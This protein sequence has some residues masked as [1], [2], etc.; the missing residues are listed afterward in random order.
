VGFVPTMGALHAG[1]LSLI[2]RALQ[3]DDRVVV[4]IFVNPMQFGPK[5]DYARYPR[6]LRKDA[7]LCR[8][9]GAHALYRPSAAAMYPAGFRTRVEVEGLGEVLCGRFRPGHFSGVA[10]VVL[11]L[12]NQI[13]PHRLYLGEK[14]YQQLAVL[15]RMA[16]D[17]DLPVRV[18]GCP[19]V[20][21][22][23]GLALSS[24]NVRL[25]RS[26]RLL[27]PG[28]HDALLAG[29]VRRRGATLAALRGRMRRAARLIP[30]ARLDYL[31][32]VDARTL[33]RPA[34][35]R[36]RLRLLGALRLGKTRLIDNI[37]LP[38][39]AS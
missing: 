32:V 25:S 33:E 18:V 16:A 22:P 38:M 5:E 9:A 4:S 7:A 39:E 20:R 8:A 13:R 36:G 17:L 10:T 24:R 35:I 19:T 37:P 3:D 6:P 30:R 23:D 12:L 2:A 27:A 21:E 1:H 26:E 15:R 28:L 31:E 34:R 11:K 29:A 14:D